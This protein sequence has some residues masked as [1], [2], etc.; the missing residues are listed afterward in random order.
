MPDTTPM[1]RLTVVF[2]VL[3]GLVGAIWIYQAG[4]SSPA[5]DGWTMSASGPVGPTDKAMLYALRQATLWEIPAL[6]QTELAAANPGVRRLGRELSGNLAELSGQV[7]VVSARVGVELPAQPTMQQ[8]QWIDE[9]AGD[10]GAHY[11]RQLVGYLYRSCEATL[12][13]IATA[14]TETRNSDVRALAEFADPV[15]RTNLRYL[16]ATGLLR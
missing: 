10:S 15:L 9:M 14:R 3:T 7:Q 12:S 2:A 1:A 8:Q 6:Q 5:E 16:T 13:V 4:G 11:D